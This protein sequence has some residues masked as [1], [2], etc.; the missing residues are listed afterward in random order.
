ME[1]DAPINFLGVDTFRLSAQLS[2]R[3][4]VFHRS[5][6][7]Q[8]YKLIFIT[9]RTSVDPYFDDEICAASAIASSRSFASAD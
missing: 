9:C 6:S 5:A 4:H 8:L 3:D 2:A 7:S 1:P